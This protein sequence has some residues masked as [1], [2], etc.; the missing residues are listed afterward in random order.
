[1]VDSMVELKAAQKEQKMVVQSV[2]M[3][4]DSK[5]GMMVETTAVLKVA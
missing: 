3:M 2:E 5:V 4:V 1:M